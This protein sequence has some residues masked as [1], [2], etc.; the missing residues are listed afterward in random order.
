MLPQIPIDDGRDKEGK[1]K[2]GKGKEANGNG[3]SSA[4]LIAHI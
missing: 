2:E 3:L 1:D 4:I